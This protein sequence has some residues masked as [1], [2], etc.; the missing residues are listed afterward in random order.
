M[1]PSTPS[2]S[3]WLASVSLRG[4]YFRCNRLQCGATGMSGDTCANRCCAIFSTL[5]F[6]SAIEPRPKLAGRRL[7]LMIKHRIT[8]SIAMSRGTLRETITS[9]RSSRE[10]LATHWAALCSIA[11]DSRTTATSRKS[12]TGKSRKK[13]RSS[14][15]ENA[16]GGCASI[17]SMTVFIFWL[18]V[19]FSLRVL[20]TFSLAR[21]GQEGA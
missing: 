3:Y 13:A 18:T 14:A 12:S 8:S 9:R 17:L 2:H 6:E 15:G 7:L 21:C 20:P 1:K 19:F 16:C 4:K 5:D 11:L 10:K